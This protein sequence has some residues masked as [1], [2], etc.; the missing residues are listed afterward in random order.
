MSEP[1]SFLSRIGSALF[2]PKPST[3][4]AREKVIPPVDLNVPVTN[5][6]LVAAL[7]RHRDAKTSE[8]EAEIRAEFKRAV[9][10]VAIHLD[11]PPTPTSEGQAVFE[12]GQ[13]ISVVQVEDAQGKSL[14]A[15]FTDH[16][17]KLLFT[18]QSNST[19]VMPAKE[20]M[21]FALGSGYSGLVVN[22]ATLAT[23]RLDSPD[24]RSM[25]SEM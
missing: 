4:P 24:I 22:P 1:K 16:A 5:P 8:S 23:M 3:E 7:A 20:A 15:L 6:G 10:L 17:E 18:S 2:G 9:F 11:R 21:T 14:L 13:K 19:L 25:L 12:T